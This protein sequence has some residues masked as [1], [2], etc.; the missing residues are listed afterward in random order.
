MYDNRYALLLDDP[1]F[2]VEIRDSSL[3]YVLWKHHLEGEALREK[4]LALLSIVQK[5]KPKAWLGNARAMYYTTVQ[6]ARWLFEHFLPTLIESSIVRYARLESPQS[7]LMLDSMKLQD[8]ISQLAQ[9]AAG[10]LEFKFFTDEGLA[11]GWLTARF[12][13]E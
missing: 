9:G 8:R 1:D 4:Y 13:R 11:L 6:D 2:R 5:F 12:Y 3:L 7:L 10:H